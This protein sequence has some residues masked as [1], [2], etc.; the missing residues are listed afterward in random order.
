MFVLVFVVNWSCCRG[1]HFQKWLFVVIA[2]PLTH[3][4]LGVASIQHQLCTRRQCVSWQVSP[5]GTGGEPSAVR[6]PV[7]WRFWQLA[8]LQD[9]LVLVSIWQSRLP[10]FGLGAEHHHYVSFI[11]T[12]SYHIL[13]ASRLRVHGS[14]SICVAARDM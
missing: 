2:L 11:S 4:H 14:L 5:D 6:L 1:C 13:G 8:W 3:F 10:V 9:Y 12:G 7:W